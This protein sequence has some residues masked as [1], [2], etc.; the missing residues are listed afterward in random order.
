[1]SIETLLPANETQE[2]KLKDISIRSEVTDYRTLI[3]FSPL[4]CDEKLIPSLIKVLNP[5]TLININEREVINQAWASHRKIGTIESV[6]KIVHAF[7]PFASVVEWNSRARHDKS[8][9]DGTVI[10]SSTDW[11]WFEYKIIL[12]NQL[13]LSQKK[14]LTTALGKYT[15]VRCVL[16]DFNAQKILFHDNSFK[17]N[18][19]YTYGGYI[20]G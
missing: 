14:R 8:M 17:R 1:M 18:N 19:S 4:S 11:A 7:D 16:K 6:K 5:V 13:T 2:L 9:R 15:P 10:Y 3:D 20:N 12:K